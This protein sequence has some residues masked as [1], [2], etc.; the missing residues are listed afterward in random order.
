VL[1]HG[2]PELIAAVVRAA[3][4][5]TCTRGSTARAVQAE[6][7]INAWKNYLAAD[8]TSCPRRRSRSVSPVP[9]RRL[10]IQI[11]RFHTTAG[12]SISSFR[13]KKLT[14]AEPRCTI[15]LKTHAIE[16]SPPDFLDAAAAEEAMPPPTR[17]DLFAE[18]WD[19]LE[20]QTKA[21]LRAVSDELER[22]APAVI[23]EIE[24]LSALVE[25]GV[26]EAEAEIQE[27]ADRDRPGPFSR[28]AR[29]V[30]AARA[31]ERWYEPLVALHDIHRILDAGRLEAW[32]SLHNGG[33][34]NNNPALGSVILK[35]PLG[36][37]RR[38]PTLRPKRD[39]NFRVADFFGTLFRARPKIDAG[40]PEAGG[41][42]VNRKLPLVYKMLEEEALMVEPGR[43]DIDFVV[44]FVP[45]AELPEEVKIEIRPRENDQRSYDVIA[46]DLSTG[47]HRLCPSSSMP[48]PI[49]SSSPRWRSAP[50]RWNASRMRPR[51][52]E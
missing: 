5:S 7:H 28:T 21:T 24:R 13:F 19:V 40:G 2:T 32:N 31:L 11:Q 14:R 39:D 1:Q 46:R 26:D 33:R 9:T 29:Y 51:N 12:L 42:A 30:I 47:R 6:N 27:W 8:R 43:P 3:A 20:N 45:L 36:G 34:L 41:D 16:E 50:T 23:A 17:A 10:G 18:I 4:P 25:A 15:Y 38:D 37:R 52:S 22:N 35:R 49:S 44:G 48:V